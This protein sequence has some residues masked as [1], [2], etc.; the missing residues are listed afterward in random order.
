V[1]TNTELNATALLAVGALVTRLASMCYGIFRQFPWRDK[2]PPGRAE[3][4]HRAQD[5]PSHRNDAVLS[6]PWLPLACASSAATCQLAVATLSVI[7]V[8]AATDG[9][10][11]ASFGVSSIKASVFI[12]SIRFAV[13][14]AARLTGHTQPYA[15][16]GPDRRRTSAEFGYLPARWRA[17]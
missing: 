14:L 2:A 10:L 8:L 12:T 3:S 13:C 1:T 6:A 15:W 17:R 11:P 5:R 9:G 16:P 7:F 4:P